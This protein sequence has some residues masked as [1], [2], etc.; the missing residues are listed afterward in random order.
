MAWN[1]PCLCKKWVYARHSH[2][3]SHNVGS[4]RGIIFTQDAV[5]LFPANWGSIK[6]I[7]NFWISHHRIFFPLFERRHS[8]RS[9]KLQ[10]EKTSKEYILNQLAPIWVFS[11]TPTEEN[12]KIWWIYEI[13]AIHY[14]GDSCM[15]VLPVSGCD[16]SGS[17]VLE[18][19]LHVIHKPGIYTTFLCDSA[20]SEYL[21]FSR[22]PHLT[23]LYQ[24]M[25]HS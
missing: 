24:F 11:L 10:N 4:M 25:I 15:L 6:T 23:R 9:F 14:P 12:M 19:A 18:H 21:K 20:T 2:F 3:S 8:N 16:L 13:F 5:N 7:N 1:E 22:Q 17:W